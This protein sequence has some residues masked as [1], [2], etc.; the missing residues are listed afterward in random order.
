MRRLHALQYFFAVEHLKLA[1]T[2]V[3]DIH[4]EALGLKFAINQLT[5]LIS[6]IVFGAIATGFGLLPMFW[7]NAAMMAGGGMT[8]RFK[9]L[10]G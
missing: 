10:R 1:R 5:K 2:R 3:H 7:I 8:S 6:P 4:F 9:K